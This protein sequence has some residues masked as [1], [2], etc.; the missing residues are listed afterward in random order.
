MQV[1]NALIRANKDFEFLVVPGGGHGLL[2]T[3][4]GWRRLED[5]FTRHLKPS[6]ATTGE[7]AQL[8][9]N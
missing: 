6:S 4:Y 2:R 3:P 7:L 9:E 5:F 8:P 1:V